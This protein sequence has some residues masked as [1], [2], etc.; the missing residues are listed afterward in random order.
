LDHID[1]GLTGETFDA[2]VGPL[3]ELG[4]DPILNID[5]ASLPTEALEYRVTASLCSRSSD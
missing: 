1:P 4:G 5:F 3:V 2:L